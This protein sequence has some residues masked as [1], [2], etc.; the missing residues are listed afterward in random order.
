MDANGNIILEVPI[1]CSVEDADLILRACNHQE[2][3]VTALED[4]L[5]LV[6]NQDGHEEIGRARKV[7]EEARA[8]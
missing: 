5:S 2:K 1:D 6:S 3:L 7:L 8:A 4:L